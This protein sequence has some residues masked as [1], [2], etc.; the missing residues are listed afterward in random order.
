M[1]I[2]L[3]SLRTLLAI[4]DEQS[5]AGAANR[6]HRTQPAI[7]QQMRRL[8]EQLGVPLFQRQGRNKVLTAAGERLVTYARRLTSLNDEAVAAMHDEQ[9]SGRV[10]IGS[11]ADIADTVLPKMLRRF[12]RANPELS[13]EIRV[14]R[15]P[16]LMEQLKRAEIDLAVSTRFDPN[17]ESLVLRT[18]PV[19]WLC[20]ADYGQVSTQPIPLVLADEPSIFRRI[21]LETLRQHGLL[22][23]ERYVAPNLAGLRASVLAGLGITA[24]STEMITPEL[25]VLGERE[26]LP[27]LPEITFYLHLRPDATSE[28][29]QRLFLLI[30]NQG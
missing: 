11:T 26:G 13:M 9:L 19:V 24:R 22:W 28:A 6:V 14:D 29:A 4:F 25:R 3:N 10:C 16:V 15:S 12:A 1:H 20:A 21:A 18:S 2:D 30:G 17:Y 7:S 5:F 8:E 23:K 27:R